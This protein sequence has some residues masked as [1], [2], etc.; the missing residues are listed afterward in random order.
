MLVDL[1]SCQCAAVLTSLVKHWSHSTVLAEL[2]V[3]QV[4]SVCVDSA[5]QSK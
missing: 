4:T 3:E 5:K 1:N 2:L